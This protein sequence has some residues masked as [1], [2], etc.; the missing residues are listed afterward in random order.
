MAA[1]S[2]ILRGLAVSFARPLSASKIEPLISFVN[3]VAVVSIASRLMHVDAQITNAISNDSVQM[4]IMPIW[5]LQITLG[6]QLAYRK[7]TMTIH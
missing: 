5:L 7:S 4:R 6:G 1:A 3:A 2:T